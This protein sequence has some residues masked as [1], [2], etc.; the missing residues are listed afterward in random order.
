MRQTLPP[1]IAANVATRVYD[2]KDS[3]SF[4]EEFNIGFLDN[5]KINAKQDESF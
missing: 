5:F 4:T 1:S 3:Y 2:I